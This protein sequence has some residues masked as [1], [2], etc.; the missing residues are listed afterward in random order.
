MSYII[1]DLL[2][3]KMIKG[4]YLYKMIRNRYYIVLIRVKLPRNG[5]STPRSTLLSLQY[6]KYD[7]LQQIRYLQ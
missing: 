2:E 3:L 5:T 6:F 4:G 7:L 1:R